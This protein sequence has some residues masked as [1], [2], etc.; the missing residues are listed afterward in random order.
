MLMQTDGYPSEFLGLFSAIENF[1]DKITE[2]VAGL[3]FKR[4]QGEELTAKELK[5]ELMTAEAAA[6][7]SI[8]NKRPIRID[9][10][11]Q[12]LARRTG[13][14]T[15]PG[16]KPMPEPVKSWGS[17]PGKRQSWTFGSLLDVHVRERRTRAQMEEA[18][19]Q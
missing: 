2:P 16:E 18:G 9:V 1:G 7:L 5:T 8:E 17:G 4:W 13:A 11:R 15:Q 3:L 10:I 19:D 12:A 14:R 6:L